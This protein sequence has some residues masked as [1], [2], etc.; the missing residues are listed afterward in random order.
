MPKEIYFAGRI[1]PVE[2]FDTE[3]RLERVFNI[4]LNDRRG[5]I[6]NLINA[7]N[8]F[9]PYASEI[10]SKYSIHSDFA[11]I[12]PVESEFNTRAYSKSGASGPWQIMS[13]TAKMYGLRVDNYCDERNLLIK[14]TEAAA[15]HLMMLNDIFN[16]DP[17]LVLAAYNNGDMNVR[18]VLESQNAEDFWDIRSNT[19]TESYVEK[20]VVYKL[21]LED[22][23][24]YGFKKPKKKKI[25]E[26]ETCTIS[27]GPNDL[28]FTEI[29]GITGMSYREF[30]SVNP[31]I[32]FGSYKTGGYLSKYTS[33]EVIV[34]EGTSEDLLAK[35]EENDIIENSIG[36]LIDVYEVKYNDKIES[37]AFKY[38]VDW[39]ELSTVNDLEIIT[40][41]SGGETAKIYQGQKIRIIR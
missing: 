20:V 17:F 11:Y 36:V 35:L 26:Y 32:N 29:C 9:I 28:S 24:K 37:I 1:V 40:L 27:L 34:P 21:I 23:E 12:I 22:P 10:L 31:H 19:E 7:K 8:D 38:G 5:F 14:S 4:L 15:E 13:A 6:Q 25:R 3:K 2:K 39:R 18:T 41:P 16:N 30:Y 33:M